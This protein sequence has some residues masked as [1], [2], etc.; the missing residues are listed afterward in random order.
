MDSQE[1]TAPVE[2]TGSVTWLASRVNSINAK[3]WDI[4][5]ESLTSVEKIGAGRFWNGKN[6]DKIETIYSIFKKFVFTD[7]EV[8][9]EATEEQVARE[10]YLQWHRDNERRHAG[11]SKS[12]TMTSK[13]ATVT[14]ADLRATSS[15][16]SPSGAKNLGEE[17][18]KAARSSLGKKHV[19][20]I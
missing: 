2:D 4:P 5:N 15:A 6:N 9:N 20:K 18:T 12:A 8:T 11:N 7:W 16:T 19:I 10:S 17:E 13:T 3:E 1:S 14:S